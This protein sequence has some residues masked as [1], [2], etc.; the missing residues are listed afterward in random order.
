MAI[1]KHTFLNGLTVTMLLALLYGQADWVIYAYARWG[2]VHFPE[3]D[4][5]N[6]SAFFITLLPAAISLFLKRNS[7]NVK[8]RKQRVIFYSLKVYLIFGLLG[9]SYMAFLSVIFFLSEPK[10]SVIQLTSPILLLL[11]SVSVCYLLSRLISNK[12]EKH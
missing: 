6:A 10:L 3:F 2:E 4:D 5:L 7:E 8:S 9:S 12:S 1:S 11:I